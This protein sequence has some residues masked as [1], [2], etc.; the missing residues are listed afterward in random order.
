[1]PGARGDACGG[2]DSPQMQGPPDGRAVHLGDGAQRSDAAQWMVFPKAAIDGEEARHGRVARRRHPKPFVMLAPEQG[3][4]AERSLF[5]RDREETRWQK[6]D[7]ARGCAKLKGLAVSSSRDGGSTRGGAGRR[8]KARR[9]GQLRWGSILLTGAESSTHGIIPL[10]PAHDATAGRAAVGVA[11]R[12]PAQRLHLPVV[13]PV[14]T[15]LTIESN[16]G[17]VCCH[18]RFCLLTTV[19]STVVWASEFRL[20]GI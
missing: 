15:G 8:H 4:G 19:K 17:S 6:K 5:R 18:T 11:R 10:C 16:F 20:A 3:A 13:E 1:M 9:W 14:A 2:V 12:C 7:E